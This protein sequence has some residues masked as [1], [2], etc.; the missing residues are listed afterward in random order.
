MVTLSFLFSS[1]LQACSSDP[2]GAAWLVDV[3]GFAA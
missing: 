3:E 1:V 2:A